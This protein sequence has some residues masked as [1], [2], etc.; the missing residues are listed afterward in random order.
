M[1]QQETHIPYRD[2]TLV[3]LCQDINLTAEKVYLARSK[4]DKKILLI[5]AAVLL[6]ILALTWYFQWF[7][8]NWYRGSIVTAAIVGWFFVIYLVNQLLINR[9]KRATSPKQHLR[10]AKCL[11]LWNRLSR[12]IMVMIILPWPLWLLLDDGAKVSITLLTAGL[13]FVLA[14]IGA[15][16]DE[17]FSDGLTELEYRLEE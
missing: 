4:K 2:R 3:E 13:F 15:P 9:M 1:E 11:K 6:G 5:G 12:A 10:L 17:D 14:F 7:D 8:I 16:V